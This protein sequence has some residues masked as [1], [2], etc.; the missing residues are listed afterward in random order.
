[1]NK[2]QRASH[3]AQVD[4]ELSRLADDMQLIADAMRPH[5]AG[6]PET[7]A[8]IH[9]LEHYATRIA[10]TLDYLREMEP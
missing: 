5:A 7:A 3:L 9:D 1:M 2:H 4:R 8:H 6:L 10:S